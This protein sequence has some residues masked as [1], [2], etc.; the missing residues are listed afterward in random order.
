MRLERDLPPELAGRAELGAAE[1]RALE[2]G[3]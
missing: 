3:G 2:A 1:Y